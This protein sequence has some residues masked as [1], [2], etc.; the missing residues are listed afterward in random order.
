MEK[1]EKRKAEAGGRQPQ[2]K[3]GQQ[4]WQPEDAKLGVMVN[5]LSRLTWA[6]VCPDIQPNITLST[7]VKVLLDESHIQIGGPS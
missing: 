1:R 2:V 4:R 5:F 6:T 7:P 3:E